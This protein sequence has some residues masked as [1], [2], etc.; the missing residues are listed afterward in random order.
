[1]NESAIF[2]GSVAAAYLL[3]GIIAGVR[4]HGSASAILAANILLGWTIIG[5]IGALIW[6][7]TA[8]GRR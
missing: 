1:M 5:W 7:L 3:P 4:G 2:I 8:T 6:S